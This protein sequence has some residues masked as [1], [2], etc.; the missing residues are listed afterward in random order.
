M[1]TMVVNAATSFRRLEQCA[2]FGNGLYVRLHPRWFLVA[3]PPV[4]H[5][6]LPKPNAP[7]RV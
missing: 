7:K 6:P 1:D 2:E 3:A 5:K 4:P